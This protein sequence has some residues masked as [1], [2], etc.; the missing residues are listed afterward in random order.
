[1]SEE[2][3]MS[4]VIDE[5]KNA[6]EEDLREVIEKWFSSTRTQGM[7][8]GASAIAIAI[9]DVINKNLKNG[10]NSSHRDFQRAVKRIL[11][12]ISVQLKQNETLQNDLKEEVTEEIVDDRTAE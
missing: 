1:M 10:M 3:K 7:K 12:I 9:Y 2:I 11:E 5:V 8:I 4:E 6:S